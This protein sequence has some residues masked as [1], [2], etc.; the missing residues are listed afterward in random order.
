MRGI[1]G[2]HRGALWVGSRW[3]SAVVAPGGGCDG[4]TRSRHVQQGERL[5]GTRCFWQDTH[6]HAGLRSFVNLSSAFIPSRTVSID[7]SS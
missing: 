2:A 3:E 4:Y 7:Q 5:R 1:V 6:T